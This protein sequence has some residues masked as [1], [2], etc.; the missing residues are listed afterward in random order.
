MATPRFGALTSEIGQSGLNEWGGYIEEDFLRELR[1]K[2]AYRRY[3][4]MRLNSPVAGALLMAIELAMRGV[5]TQFVSD[6]DKDP[7]VDLL[8]EA[9]DSMSHNWND[10]LSSAL[11]FLPFGFSLF[12]IVYKRDGARILWR[13]FAFRG[14]D[15]VDKWLLDKNGGIQGFTQ[16]AEPSYEPVDIPI[17]KLLLYRTR[18][19]KN[20]PEG[21]SIFRTA[22]L[23]YYYL[24][25]IQQIEGIGIERDLAGMPVIRLPEGATTGSDSTSDE[26]VAK[27]IV[28]NIRRDEQ[29]G[30]TIPPGW[31][32]ELLSTGGTR[33]FDTNSIVVRYESRI[34]MSALAQFLLLGQDRV[35][36]YSLS[37]DQT[38]FF[39]MG[40]NAML[41]IVF[42]TFF[43]YACKRLL[44]LNG[45]DA[46]GL[47][48]EHSP[49]GDVDIM[50]IADTLQKLGRAI[51]MTAQDEKWL[52]SI[53]NMPNLEIEQIEEEREKAAQRSAEISRLFQPG[54]QEQRMQALNQALIEHYASGRSP[55][56]DIRRDW[57]GRLHRLQ[58]TFFDEQKKRVE[59]EARRAK[60]GE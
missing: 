55:D 7:R 49:A 45:Y 6:I 48:F 36:A 1:G 44:K 11:T 54:N 30:V 21:R 29:E 56:D 18:V 28:R 25:N 8:N 22:W 60:R 23:S 39:V 52:R 3:N 12:E 27:K 58:K 42:D 31:E 26:S 59:K 17:E 10:H 47:S 5:D 41:D 20:N 53:L 34:L 13:K 32:L 33:Q 16:I 15:T 37:K 19:E 35:G 40:V 14:Q 43:E 50:A 24:K 4:E 2:D 57:E 38:D 9:L 46:E 51:T